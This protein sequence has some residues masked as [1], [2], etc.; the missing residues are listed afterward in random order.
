M[1][2]LALMGG[3]LVVVVLTTALTWQIVG[4]ADAQV[5]D[6]PA[7]PLNVAAPAF[8]PTSTTQ[9]TA[10]STTTLMSVPTTGA[11]SPTSVTTSSTS[12]TVA[13]SEWSLKTVNTM[14]GSVVLK[15]RPGEVV[16]QATTPAPGYRAEVEKAGPP[17]VEVEFES[18]NRKVAVH[19][20]WDGGDL[21]VE[22]SESD[23]D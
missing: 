13:A 3:W 19:A 15:Y 9:A 17:E 8:T 16:L 14:G 7:S 21:S 5:S 12:T 4:A 20:K 22:V 10:I 18:E 6:R 2:R 23:H 1:R 11:T